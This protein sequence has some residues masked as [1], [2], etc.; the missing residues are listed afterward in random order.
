MQPRSWPPIEIVTNAPCGVCSAG[1]ALVT[2]GAAP[3]H[4]GLDGAAR[5]A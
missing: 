5:D 3:A 2:S 1:L 4:R